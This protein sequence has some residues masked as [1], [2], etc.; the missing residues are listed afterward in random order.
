MAE[1][2]PEAVALVA[3]ATI[4]QDKAEDHKRQ[5]AY[6]RR[7]AAS[8]LQDRAIVLEQLAELGVGLPKITCD[9]AEE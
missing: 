3:R 1:L 4:L 9:A 7:Q 2:T 8:C 6:H 5:T